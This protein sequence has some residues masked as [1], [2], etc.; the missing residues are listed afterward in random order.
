MNHSINAMKRTKLLVVISILA[1]VW[2][3]SYSAV[4]STSIIVTDSKQLISYSAGGSLTN[5]ANYEWWYGCSPTSAGMIIGYYDRNGYMGY[6]YGNLVPGGTAETSSFPSTAGSWNYLCQNTIASSSHVSDFYSGAFG[7]SGDDTA[8]PYHNFNCLADFMGT[9]QDSAGNG[10]GYTTFWNYTNGSPLYYNDIYSYGP[11]FYNSSGM[12]GIYEYVDYSGYETTVL[13]NQYID[14]VGATYGFTYAQYM[15]EIDAGRPVL[16]HV[17]DHTMLG[18]GYFN[19][20][21]GA[22]YIN[23][24]DTWGPNGQ[25]PGTMA[26]GGSYPYGNDQLDFFAVTVM[27]LT[28]IPA[29]GAMLLGSIGLGL[30]GWL[31]RRRTL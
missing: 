8:G 28:P 21:T 11:A 25:N 6:N 26:W 29:P 12:Y 7:A 31:R 15:A 4:A 30:L 24:Y 18:Y 2:C 23:V 20:P 10:N 14:T 9:S 22:P 3:T 19:D 17:E 5:T 16:V 1:F 27:G 13:Y